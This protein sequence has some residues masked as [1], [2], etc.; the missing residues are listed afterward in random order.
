MRQYQ[1]GSCSVHY[2][3][4]SEDF[5]PQNSIVRSVFWKKKKAGGSVENELGR[6]QRRKNQLGGY[7]K[8]LN[9]CHECQ[10]PR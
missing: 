2:K 8:H 3:E 4:P 7:N 9:E 6:D 10:G 1:E 5:K